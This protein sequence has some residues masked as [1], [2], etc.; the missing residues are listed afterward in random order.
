[1]PVPFSTTAHAPHNIQMALDEV[2]P[3]AL[4]YCQ[5]YRACRAG[6]RGDG[7]AA[8]AAVDLAEV[9]AEKGLGQD[10]DTLELLAR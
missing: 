1:M 10:V 8:E 6:A 2:E 3:D 5:A 9:M 7:R 4:S